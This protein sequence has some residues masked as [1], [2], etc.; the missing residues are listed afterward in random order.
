MGM[1]DDLNTVIWDKVRTRFMKH[2]AVSENGC[3]LWQGMTNGTYPTFHVLGASKLVYAHRLSFEMFKEPIRDG[4]VIMHTCDTPLCVNP[5]H[6]IQGTQQQ[7]LD[8]MFSR[9]R[10]FRPGMKHPLFG[11]DNPASKITPE[12]VTAIRQEQGLS[13]RKLARKYGL[14]SSQIHRI[15]KGQSW[16]NVQESQS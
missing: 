9:G 2:I 7:N 3:W 12:I 5:D 4:M 8:D 13:V 16:P 15:L 14:G 10:G 6:L 1:I 11:L